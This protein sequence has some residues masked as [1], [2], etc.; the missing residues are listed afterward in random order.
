MQRGLL[1]LLFGVLFRSVMLVF[2]AFVSHPLAYALVLAAAYLPLFL[3]ARL[4]TGRRPKGAPASLG[5]SLLYT[6]LLL[7]PLLF[8]SMTLSRLAELLAGAPLATALPPAPLFLSLV[9]LPALLEELFFRQ[10]VLSLLSDTGVSPLT[11]LLLSALLFMAAHGQAAAFPYTL[12]AGLVLGLVTLATGRIFPSVLLHLANNA[13]SLCLM[14][15]TRAA[16]IA[17]WV[18]VGVL[19]LPSLYLLFIKCKIHKE[20]SRGKR[21]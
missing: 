12:A 17:V 15:G 16:Y 4:Y 10:G 8:C 13:L 18:T 11:A 5:T 7:C 19:S 6:A 1:L 14:G 21:V 9:L 20:I 2:T 3:G